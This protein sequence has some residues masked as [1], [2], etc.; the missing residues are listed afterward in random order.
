MFINWPDGA[1]AFSPGAAAPISWEWRGEYAAGR[2]CTH[3]GPF[4][5]VEGNPGEGG[6]EMS[7][8]EYGWG[9]YGRECLLFTG[10]RGPW[11]PRTYSKEHES[12]VAG[13][14]GVEEEDPG[15]P[16][17]GMGP[18]CLLRWLLTPSPALVARASMALEDADAAAAALSSSANGTLRTGIRMVVHMRAG[19]TTFFAGANFQN[20]DSNAAAACT[21]KRL[22]ERA[23]PGLAFVVVVVSDSKAGAAGL[24]D[25]IRSQAAAL[26]APPPLTVVQLSHSDPV[27]IDPGEYRKY[28]S[29]FVQVDAAA[30]LG[31][32]AEWGVMAG[33]GGAGPL[34][35]LLFADSAFPRT[36]G[37][38][39]SGAGTLLVRY[40][41]GGCVVTT[42]LQLAEVGSGI[43][44]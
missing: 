20:A 2:N 17:R 30:V 15:W 37:V 23:A 25:S 43:R 40:G 18:A 14:N 7:A 26:P 24:A 21:L 16:A 35:E 5:G 13:L 42:P 36:A 4:A 39:A 1:V 22:Q 41:G 28:N 11:L 32:L 3:G 44:A 9:Q 38:Y 8:D 33:V 6:P 31:T 10:N 12:F 29:S 27:H 34:S 19:D